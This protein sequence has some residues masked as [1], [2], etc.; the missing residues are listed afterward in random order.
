MGEVVLSQELPDVLDRI[1][2]RRIRRQVEQADVGGDVQP[3]AGLVPAGTVEHDHGMGTWC[4]VLADL[5]KVQVHRLDIHTRQHQGCADATV[6][7]DRAE[8]IGPLVA[9]VARGRRAR[10]AR[11]PGVGQAALLADPGLILPPD[12][13]RPAARGLWN[14]GGHQSGEVFLCASWAAS[15]CLG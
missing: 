2:L 12:L 6:R 7:A 15:S 4:H 11:R 3:V 9:C 10:A 5:G 13:E 8:Q 1:E 14:D